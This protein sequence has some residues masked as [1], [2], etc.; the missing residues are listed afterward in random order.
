LPLKEGLPADDFNQAIMNSSTRKRLRLISL[1][2]NDPAIKADSPRLSMPH[3]QPLAASKAR[4]NS[5]LSKSHL[6]Q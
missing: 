5:A 2:E 1:R 3:H 6:P 4:A